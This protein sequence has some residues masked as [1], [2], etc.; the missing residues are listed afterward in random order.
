MRL[1]ANAPVTGAWCLTP[2]RTPPRGS[3]WAWRSSSGW[4]PRGSCRATAA[5]WAWRR[6]TSTPTSAT[7][8]TRSSSSSSSRVRSQISSTSSGEIHNIYGRYLLELQTIHRFSQ[9]RRRP[10]LG[11]SPGWNTRAVS[12][13]T[14]SRHYAKHGLLRYCKAFAKVRWMQALVVTMTPHPLIVGYCS[15]TPP[16]AWGA[17]MRPQWRR[18]LPLPSRHNTTPLSGII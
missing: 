13:N 18:S 4:R 5:G 14:L 3:S 17:T 8:P 6:S 2:T 15:I 10:L 16:P 11:S 12:F 1:T 7:S 9:S